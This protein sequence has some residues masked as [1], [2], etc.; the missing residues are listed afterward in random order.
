MHGEELRGRLLGGGGKE[1][2]GGE[3]G[4]AELKEDAWRK[5]KVM[6]YEMEEH[7]CVGE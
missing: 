1:L 2:G 4:R 6:E 3:E 7:E 5:I